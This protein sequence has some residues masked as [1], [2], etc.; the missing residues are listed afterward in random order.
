MRQYLRI[1][2]FD[3]HGAPGAG[4]STTRADRRAPWLCRSQRHQPSL[5]LRRDGRLPT[6]PRPVIECGRCS[7]GRRSFDATLDGLMMNTELSSDEEQRR[8]APYASSI[9]ARPIRLAGSVREREITVSFPISSSFIA[10]STACRHRVP[11][12]EVWEIVTMLKAIH[13]SE[14]IVAAREKGKGY[15]SGR[16]VA[17]PA[18]HPSRRTHRSGGCGDFDRLIAGAD[19][20]PTGGHVGDERAVLVQHGG[21]FISSTYRPAAGTSIVPNRSARAAPIRPMSSGA[22]CPKHEAPTEAD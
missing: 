13:A 9:C 8:V 19:D 11:S 3:V 22:S 16:E 18:P 6:G 17:R 4:L 1:E 15:S 20:A 7:I 5:R 12:T 14:D 10:N 2:K 21:A